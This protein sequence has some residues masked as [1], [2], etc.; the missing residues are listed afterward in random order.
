LSM[1]KATICLNMIVKDEA[2]VIRRCLATVR[3]LI[4]FWVIVDTGSRDGTQA[5]ISEFLR[6]LPGELIERP[7]VDFAHNRS[8]ALAAARDKAHYTLV[9]DADETLECE[10]AFVMPPLDLDA[11]NLEVSYGGCTYL[12]KALIS[13]RLAWRYEGV[14]HEHISC[15]VPHSEG[16]VPG[17]RTIPHPDGARARNSNTFR[18]DALILERALITEPDNS[19]YVFYLAQSYRDGGEFELAGRH[20]RRRVD[21]GGWSEEIWYSLYQ[22]AILYERTQKAW[23]EIMEAY[24]AAYEYKSD[25]AEP[26]YRI[27][28]RYQ[29]KGEQRTAHL[30]FAR[31]MQ[32]PAPSVD[33]LFVETTVYKF[34]LPIDYAVASYYI[35]D[36]RAAIATNNALLAGPDLPASMVREVTTNR[37]FSLDALLPPPAAAQAARSG[38]SRI[39]V[40]V[41]P[42]SFATQLDDT[43][44]SLLRQEGV[45]F[46]VKLFVKADA[47]VRLPIDPRFTLVAEAAAGVGRAILDYATS[48][49][50][51]AILLILPPGEKLTGHDAL[52]R[53]LA[54]FRDPGCALVHGQY[55]H[56][57]G[58]LGGALPAA[59]AADFD[60][61]HGDLAGRAVAFRANLAVGL[62]SA[63]EAGEPIVELAPVLF[64]NAR[65]A[66]TR[67]IDAPLTAIIAPP[68]RPRVGGAPNDGRPRIS[69]LMV[70]RDRLALAKRSIDCFAAQTYQN[71]ELVVVTNGIKAYC[72][73]LRAHA[74]HLKID[75]HFI[76]LEEPDL[77]LGRLRNISLD[78]G[79][80]DILCQWDDDDCNHP[81]RLARQ[82]EHMFR[83]NARACLMTDH[84]QFLQ[85]AGIVVWVDWTLGGRDRIDQLLP[86]TMMMYRD[87]RFRYPEEGEYAMRGEDTLFLNELY[88]GVPVASLVGHGYLYLY[89]YH[90]RNTFSKDHHYHLST[91]SRTA[92]DMSVEADRIREALSHYPIEKPV[93]VGGRDGPSFVL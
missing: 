59:D 45:D 58:K 50:E 52:A 92:A 4:D 14:L 89:T 51:E 81:E 37:R 63:A 34:L 55:R 36:H 19:R 13:R 29:A 15:N 71:R 1:S 10:P 27:G 53:W 33:R 5:I 9:I 56:A 7:W 70:T 31:A 60:A 86:G 42:P 69:C 40:C 78:T 35:G 11:Y 47:T 38:T 49:P 93:I 46:S 64:T 90:G 83:E 62:G 73:A 91:Y 76:H 23:P 82:A 77:T 12:R 28:M 43:I 87:E 75:T 21:M 65:F 72:E 68:C 25:R 74:D 85:D 32:I 41:L 44:E 61:R 54:P 66:A 39:D 48:L 30:F 6:D 22:I 26:L 20:Y 84:L 79:M 57:D 16:F 8:E 67:F 18:D 80:G 2:P 17:L 24:L 88:A 3:P